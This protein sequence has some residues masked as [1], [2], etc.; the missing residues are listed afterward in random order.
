MIRNSKLHLMFSLVLVLL[1]TTLFAAPAFAQFDTY[2][3]ISSIPGGSTDEQHR[4]WIDVVSL[5]QTWPGLGKKTCDV[6]V[7]K[8]LDVAGPRLWAAAVL[9]QP[10][11]E[12]RIEVIK[13]GG[14]TRFKFYEIRLTN[15]RITSITTGGSNVLAESV[16]LTGDTLT[17]TYYSQG[18]DGNVGTVVTTDP[19]IQCI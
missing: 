14:D 18:V 5:R 2:M 1:G 7:V 16:A 6:E 4:N 3:N 10:L 11:G 15:A 8:G 19:P 13:P 12:V 9:K 17:I